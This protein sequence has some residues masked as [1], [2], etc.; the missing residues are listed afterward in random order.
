MKISSRQTLFKNITAFTFLQIMNYVFPL[1]TIPYVVRVLGVEKFGLVSFA[2]AF[3]NY[4]ALL[5][6][7]GFNYSATRSISINRD[8]P[9]RIAEILFSVY[10]IKSVLFIL[11]SII[12]LLTILFVP[13]LNSEKELCLVS[14][15][16]VLGTMLLPQWYFQ[17]IGKMSV[18]TWI[19]F[20]VRIAAVILIFVLVHTVTDYKVYAFL[21]SAGG[22][23]IGFL[24]FLFVIKNLRKNQPFNGTTF[25]SVL[26][27]GSVMFISNASINLYTSSNTFI[28]G[29][30]ASPT[31]VG[32]WAAADKIRIAVQGILSPI[33]LGFYPHLAHLFSQSKT[34]AIAFI[35]KSFLPIGLIGFLVS[36]VLLLFAEPISSLLLGNKFSHSLILIKLISFLPFIILLSNF[37][38][39]QILLNLNGSKEF[40]F[41]VFIAGIFN[42]ILS[43]IIVPK[44]LAI[45]TAIS[46]LSTEIIVTLLMIYFAERRLRIEGNNKI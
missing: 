20:C 23:L 6:D 12:F 34:M 11:S 31:I 19:T 9:N 17:G 36:L 32:Y 41:T 10:T 38:G 15:L 29:L 42:L 26:K 35:K 7:Y 22:V 24:T 4:F 28:L 25:F 40:S 1:I 27:E 37:F 2:A 16:S 30:F 39:I 43:F 45:G 8:N 14:Y 21:N 3:V 44:L 46:V 13:V 33:T 5:T 18:I